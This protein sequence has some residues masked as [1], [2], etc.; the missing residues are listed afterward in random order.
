M[1]V[2]GFRDKNYVTD[3][4]SYEI[5]YNNEIK[6]IEPSF[7]IIKYVFK[8]LLHTS[9]EWF[10]MFYAILSIGLKIIATKKITKYFYL[11]LMVF[12]GDL[13]LQQD[14]TQIRAAVALG[15]M[16]LSIKY[17]FSR[18][19]RQFFCCC[20]AGMFFH[21]SAILIIPLWFINS[22]TINIKLCFILIAVSYLLAI[23][24]FNPV[25]LLSYINTPLVKD[26]VGK[27]LISQK[28]QD[29]TA[30]IFSVYFLV[31]LFLFSIMLI[32]Y[33]IILRENKYIVLL[34]KIQLFSIVSLLLFSQN[35]AFAL[36]FSEFYGSIGMFLFP[37]FP[38]IFKEKTFARII[39]VLVC[40]FFICLRIFRYN[41]ILI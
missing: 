35:L 3:Y 36:R 25:S 37:F 15:F 10:M 14:F 2:T 28:G 24:K 12:I 19:R 29:Y 22:K 11:T 20:A 7:L 40:S 26:R 17:I 33:D 13:F 1:L 4:S 27:Y 21:F 5:M 6:F 41:L 31:K 8:K 16:L 39:L 18:E 9:I 23:I 30:N 32:N 38:T 34:L